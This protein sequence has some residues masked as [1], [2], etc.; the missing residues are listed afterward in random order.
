MSAAGLIA[1]LIAAE[2]QPVIVQLE[3][4]YAPPPVI[5]PTA[6]PAPP[7]QVP[8][9]V[10]Q[11]AAPAAARR[12]LIEY[13]S[14][15]DYPPSALR[16]EEEGLISFRLTV[17][18]DGRVANCDI[19]ISSGSAALDAATCR[20]LRSRAR[21]VPARD[22]Q[23]QVT[24]DSV[25]GRIAWRM[26]PLPAVP[27]LAGSG[28]GP[29][30]LPGDYPAGWRP[31]DP[32]AA[33]ALWLTVDPA[34][35][36][37]AC[38]ASGAGSDPAL[39]AGICAGLTAR[40]LYAPGEGEAGAAAEDFVRAA[41]VWGPAGARPAAAP[42]ARDRTPPPDPTPLRAPPAARF[43]AFL[44]GGFAPLF[45]AGDYPA[46]AIAAGA[47]GRVSFALAID[48]DG[49]VAECRIRRSS[50]SAA[51]D[52]AACRILRERARYHPARDAAGGEIAGTDHGE[53]IW[54]LPPG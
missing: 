7:L 5:T 27:A 33:L 15:D 11:S 20:I 21:F 35:R 38:S 12:P 45:H 28:M 22:K 9:R 47:E 17:G 49:G 30:L 23:G 6:P 25:S 43:H 16:G 51:L 52:A 31:P 50:G 2:A 54:A 32:A 14:D 3:P 48:R 26:P 37:S 24:Q 40:T 4:S 29:I 10:P 13:F 39:G 44:T 53:I 8:P 36:I 1:L 34:G 18:A 42:R 19:I 46:A 41:L